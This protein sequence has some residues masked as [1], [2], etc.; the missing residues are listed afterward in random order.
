MTRP[1][2][3]P[4]PAQLR[5]EVQTYLPQQKACPDC[6]GELKHLGEDVSE[7]LEYVPR[8]SQ[9]DPSGPTEAGLRRLR[10][11]R[12]STGAQPADREQYRR[13]GTSGPRAGLEV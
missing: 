6:G 4:L 8:E 13:P 10:P 5:R 1:A 12:T 3:R 11:N 7:I 2:R 9:S